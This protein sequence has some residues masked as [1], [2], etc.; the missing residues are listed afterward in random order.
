M[1]LDELDWRNG[2]KGIRKD[3]DQDGGGGI[4]V[5]SKRGVGIHGLMYGDLHEV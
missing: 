1:Y 5:T 2:F 3:L 4:C